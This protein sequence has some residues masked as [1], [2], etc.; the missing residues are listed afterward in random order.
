MTAGIGFAQSSY[1]DFS[2]PPHNYWKRPLEDRFTKLRGDLESGRLTLDQSGERAF[3]ISLLTALD[4]PASSQLLVFSTTSLQLRLISPSNPR[5]IYF[6]E[7]LYVG[8]IP[9]GRIEIVSVDPEIGGIFYIFDIPRDGRP[10]RAERS[11]RCMNCHAGADTQYVPGL[12]IQSVIPG[13]GG[14]TLDAFRREQTGH[15]VPLEM[16][17]GGWHVTGKHGLT[18]HWG[19]LVGRLSTEGLATNRIEAGTRFD[20]ARYPAS[21]SDILAHL[22]LE[23]QTGFVNRV[24]EASYRAR[25]YLH[26]GNG[27]V[28]S[29]HAAE[30]DRQAGIITR[31]L[32]FAD[33]APLP[34]DGVEGDAAF[35][36]DFL[37][38]RRV[39]AEG[40][41]LKDFELRTR[42]FKHRCSYMIYSPVFHGLPNPMKQRVYSRLSEA[43][44][45]EKPSKEFDYLA[46]VE[47]QA[48][49]SILKETMPELR[50][51]W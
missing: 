11:D 41:S 26:E 9:G 14:G 2:Y 46:P 48:I 3:L 28:S 17:F 50:E 29:E 5:A 12:I 21:T 39:T 31:Y 30:L 7:D 36:A 42:L 18:N 32:F 19:N 43:L 8:F 24:L 6:S 49:R 25:S 35:K 27:Q 4:V 37:R 40:L 15:G 38:G 22:L 51:G 16:R 45:L 1:R 44:R 33:E 10:P 47:K 13:P 20:F 23:H 34:P